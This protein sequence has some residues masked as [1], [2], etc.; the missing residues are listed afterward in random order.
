MLANLSENQFKHGFTGIL[1]VFSSRWFTYTE[2][3]VYEK[4]ANWS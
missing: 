1:E 3:R 2:K 4:S